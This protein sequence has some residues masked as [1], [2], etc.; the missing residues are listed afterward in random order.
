MLCSVMVDAINEQICLCEDELELLGA[1]PVGDIF[2]VRLNVHY[3]EGTRGHPLDDF[4]ERVSGVRIYG[5]V[6][7]DN[8]E[9]FLTIK[10]DLGSGENSV[11]FPNKVVWVSETPPVDMLG[12]AINV[13]RFV[14]NCREFPG[15]VSAFAKVF[16]D[17]YL[18]L[19]I[20]SKRE[21]MMISY[22]P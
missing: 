17:G 9:W 20:S 5:K 13:R 1:G 7:G 2:V 15:S 19:F 4:V 12:S 16:T 3:Y 14:Q 21:E 22:R 8:Y 11:T 10:F 6:Y 18:E